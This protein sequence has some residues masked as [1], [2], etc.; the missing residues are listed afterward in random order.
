MK[1]GEIFW[2]NLDPFMGAEISKTLPVLIISN[3]INNLYS[4]NI[5]I[6]PITKSISKIYPFE[7]FVSKDISGLVYDS[8]IKTNQIRTID[9]QRLIS[10]ISEITPEIIKEVEQAIL[11]HLG[12]N[13]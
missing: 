2:A 9:K 5:T 10:K 8:K 1:R 11:I 3:D 4:Q 6:I 7:V 13:N 12:I